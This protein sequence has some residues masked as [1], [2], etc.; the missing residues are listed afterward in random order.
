MTI[1]DLYQ[2]VAGGGIYTI[3]AV[4]G[5]PLV[6]GLLSLYFK[7]SG[8]M[9]LSQGVAN[10]GIAVGL[11]AISIE[12]LA[13]VYTMDRLSVE[14]L[15]QVPLIMLLG[16]IY[17]LA[18]AVFVENRVHPGP[19]AEMRARIR[20]ALITVLA[21]AVVYYIVGKLNI[22]MLVWTSLTGFI[23]FILLLIGFLYFVARRFI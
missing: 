16:P 6:L 23:V 5:L 22:Y 9:R 11:A 12:I 3:A 14:P 18:A 2:Q 7:K 15:S 21:L 1:A 8:L 4:F 17:L 10:L 13:L 20:G 19:Q